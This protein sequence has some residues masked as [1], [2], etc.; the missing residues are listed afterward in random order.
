MTLILIAV[1]RCPA[2]VGRTLVDASWTTVSSNFLKSV[3]RHHM[4]FHLI[5]SLIARVHGKKR[6]LSKS[7]WLY[8]QLQNN[9]INYEFNYGLHNL[10]L[11]RDTISGG[12]LRWKP[13]VETRNAHDV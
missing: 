11:T 4:Q 10:S 2:Y 13:G 9:R 8:N 3:L 6:S 5:A 1:H 12:L 7:S